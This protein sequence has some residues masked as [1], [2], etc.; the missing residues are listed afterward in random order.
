MNA[1]QALEILRRAEA[2]LRARGVCHAALFGSVARGEARPDSDLDI[3]IEVDP[4]APIGVYDY[5]DLK[6][7]I[8]GLFEGPVDVVSRD[9]LKPHIRPAVSGAIY[10]F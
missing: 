1:N 7:Y 10:A 5:V 4:D 9:S 2:D 6:D 8:A 3:M